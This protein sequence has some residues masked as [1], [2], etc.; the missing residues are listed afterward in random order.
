MAKA[1][2]ATRALPVA[3][4]STSTAA[5]RLTEPG[6]HD[7][8][9]RTADTKGAAGD[10][11]GATPHR[12]SSKDRPRLG[13]GLSSLI[14]VSDLPAMAEMPVEPPVSPA[15]A[16]SSVAASAAR[17]GEVLQLP[18]DQISPN[19]HQ[20]RRTWSDETLSELAASMKTNGVL[21]PVLVRR[22][23]GGG[24]QLIAGERRLRAAR[25]AGL[26]TL[27]ALLRDVDSFTQAQLA[28]IENLH[29]DDLNPL[30]RA[31]GFRQLM[32]QL[33]LTQAELA[34]RLGL[35]RSGVANHLRLL[36][37]AEHV[38]GLVRQ[39][40]L[41]LGHAKVLAGLADASEQIRLADLVVAQDLS[42]RNLERLL[43]SPAAAPKT[44]AS[45]ASPAHLRE[46]ETSISRQLGLRV[47]MRAASKTKGRL[48]I[49]YR[50]LDEFDSLME[51]LGVKLDDA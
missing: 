18:L 50:S 25:L 16:T 21:Q 41:S 51:R 9:I 6:G 26:A 15:P 1:P 42:V 34:T 49:H 48:V 44:R 14:Q 11:K 28:L 46:V 37:L 32:E 19:P 33:G 39:G 43:S 24:Y 20:P 38:Q 12:G 4:E 47:Q 27:P 8:S 10:G 23:P 29:R 13:R 36:D 7:R 17:D 35:D 3:P 5:A 30:D 31:E 22:M 40:K 2:A 45:S